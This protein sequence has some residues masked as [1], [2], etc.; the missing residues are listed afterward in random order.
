MGTEPE[1]AEEDDY[2]RQVRLVSERPRAIPLLSEAD[3]ACRI[4]DLLQV[5]AVLDFNGEGEDPTRTTVSP[6]G[7]I[8]R[9]VDLIDRGWI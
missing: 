9:V 3:R 8:Y 6:S 4:G 2:D 1:L 5:N 7:Q